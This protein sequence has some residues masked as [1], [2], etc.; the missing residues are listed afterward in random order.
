MYQK[1]MKGLFRQLFHLAA[2]LLKYCAKDLYT[3]T[4]LFFFVKIVRYKVIRYSRRSAINLKK[5]VVK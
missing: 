2:M 4:L 3:N 1:V 5:Y